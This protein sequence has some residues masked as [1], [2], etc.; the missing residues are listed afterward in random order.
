MSRPL[1][2]VS[3]LCKLESYP[4]LRVL[5]LQAWNQRKVCLQH[6]SQGVLRFRVLSVD[7]WDRGPAELCEKVDTHGNLT[8]GKKG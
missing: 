4:T 6:D 1:F 8:P 3:A 5:G 7:L 2:T